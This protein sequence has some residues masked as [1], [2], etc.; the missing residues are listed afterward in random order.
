MPN[1]FRNKWV[2]IDDIEKFTIR[3]EE[4]MGENNQANYGILLQGTFEGC[5]LCNKCQFGLWSCNIGV[6]HKE[7]KKALFHVTLDLDKI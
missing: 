4:K 2:T 5:L 3:K 7:D 1:E 6:K